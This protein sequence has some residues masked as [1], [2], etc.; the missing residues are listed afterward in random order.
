MGCSDSKAT[1]TSDT[2]IHCEEAKGEKGAAGQEINDVEGAAGA[3]KGIGDEVKI[4]L[5]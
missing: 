2:I 3:L 4:A 5:T 1:A